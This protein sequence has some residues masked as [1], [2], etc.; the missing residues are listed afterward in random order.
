VA[1]A[2]SASWRTAAAEAA[3]S[4]AT[5]RAAAAEATGAVARNRASAAEA[6]VEALQEAADQQNYQKRARTSW[7]N[8]SG[9][10]NAFGRGGTAA[11]QRPSSRGILA[12]SGVVL[13]GVSAVAAI[14]GGGI[15]STGGGMGGGGTG[16]YGEMQQPQQQPGGG[17]TAAEAVAGLAAGPYSC[18]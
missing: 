6:K 12:E 11:F 4:A 18:T 10:Y 8:P 13:E 5:E 15:G 9:I 2:A 3:A 1:T 14:S 17:A 16:G 7:A